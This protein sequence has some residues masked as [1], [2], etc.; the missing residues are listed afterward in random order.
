MVFP[1]GPKTAFEQSVLMHTGSHPLSTAFHYTTVNHTSYASGE[2][3]NVT[4]QITV[5]FTHN[6][7]IK[8]TLDS[9]LDEFIS[10]QIILPTLIIPENL[11]LKIHYIY[12]KRV[13]PQLYNY[14]E[15]SEFSIQST[16]LNNLNSN[17]SIVSN[18]KITCV[19]VTDQGVTFTSGENIL[20]HALLVTYDFSAIIYDR[21]PVETTENLFQSIDGYSTFAIM[22][23][24]ALSAILLA[25]RMHH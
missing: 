3:Y 5:T 9:E 18:L 2:M 13:L 21:T 10:A 16:I 20:R 19:V 17:A 7:T 12:I 23:I 11:G 25:K 14:F 8:N 1:D 22:G 15:T 24:L 4:G 6:F